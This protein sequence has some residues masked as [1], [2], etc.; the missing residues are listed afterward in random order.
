MQPLNHSRYEIWQPLILALVLAGGMLLGTRL[1]DELPNLMKIPTRQS[2]QEPWDE[3]KRVVGFIESRY[4]DSLDVDSISHEAI[5]LLVSNL[6]P[7][8]YYLSGMEY[9]SFKERMNGSYIGIGIDYDMIRDT[10]RLIKIV[11]DSPAEHSGLKQGDRVLAIN[12]TLVSGV[13]LNQ[14]GAY[15]IW[16]NTDN[17]IRLKVMAAHESDE[18]S[19]EIEK[20]PV[21]LPSVPA[22]LLVKDQIGYIKITRFAS[23]TYREFMDHLE[24]LV[25]EGMQDLIIDVREN[26]G[27]SLDQVIKIL[28]QLVPERDQMLLYTEGLNTK[29][30]EYK[31]TGKTFFNIDK[32]AVLINENSVSASEVLAGSLQD[33]GRAVI[34]GRRSFGKGLV[35]EMYNLTSESAINLTVAK[36]Y[37]PSGR[38]IQKSYLDRRAYDHDIDNRIEN[39]ELFERDSAIYAETAPDT[40]LRS[41]GE[42]ITPDIFVPADSFY[43]TDAWISHEHQFYSDAFDFYMMHEEEM[44]KIIESGESLNAFE[45]EIFK[46]PIFAEVLNTGNLTKEKLLKGYLYLIK[47]HYYGDAHFFEKMINDDEEIQVAIKA[48][49]DPEN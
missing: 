24:K 14:K 4:G 44:K 23:D 31:S 19:I 18:K 39:G 22:G 5:K 42:G 35:Q 27:G 32:I 34:V 20:G 9:L 30:V 3:L 36:Y 15:Q 12:D 7:H 41:S 2:V 6:D 28:N 49:E 25:D 46:R 40:A 38:S 16:K 17:T 37:L 11:K 10:M 26:P 48:L 43:F 21:N 47:W 8:S 29:K 1:D 45:K 13:G 33:L